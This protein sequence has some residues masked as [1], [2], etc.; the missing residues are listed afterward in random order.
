M[1]LFISCLAALYGR[2]GSISFGQSSSFEEI[3]QVE[4]IDEVSIS[5]QH[6]AIYPC[7]LSVDLFGLV[8][9]DKQHHYFR[10]EF[11]SLVSY[12]LY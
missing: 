2:S 10:C 5:A 6:H 1:G 3:A 11:D 8:L 7:A 12:V 4:V 9:I